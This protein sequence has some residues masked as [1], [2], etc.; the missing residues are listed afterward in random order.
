M[1]ADPVVLG[2]EGGRALELLTER[3]SRARPQV[4]PTLAAALALARELGSELPSPARG[5]TRALWEAL[6]S[7]GAVDLSVARAIEPHLDALAILEEA[8]DADQVAPLEVA[9]DSVWGVFAAEGGG[10]LRAQRSSGGG[11]E[12][13]GPKPWCSLADRLSHALVTAWVDDDRRGLFAVDLRHPGVRHRSEQQEWVSR[14]LAEVPSTGLDLTEVP[15]VPVGDPGWY[16]E[17]P[18]FAWGGIGVAA[19]WFGA[20]VAVAR[21]VRSAALSR[22]PDQIALAHLGSVDVALGR[23]RAVLLDAAIVVDRPAVDREAASRLALRVRQVVVD[24]VEEVLSR[25]AHALGPAPLALEE[26][27]ARRISDLGVYVRQHHA[28]R[29]AS[30]LGAMLLAEPAKGEWSWW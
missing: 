12:L 11:W 4:D 22:K 3:A 16:L 23:A 1:P 25:S 8:R 21:R 5:R 26:E 2:P 30:A 14:G 15:A 27:H 29:D 6:A 13:T 7:L 10:R 28:E 24:C 20:A 17:R 9:E 19:V 18:G